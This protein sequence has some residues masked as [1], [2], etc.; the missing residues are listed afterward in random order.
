M[1]LLYGTYNPAKL[2]L[3]RR[4]LSSLPGLTLVGLQ[5]LE[6][7][8]SDAEETGDTPLENAR[9]KALAYQRHSG[10]ITLAA[11]SALY[12]NGLPEKEQ[13]AVHARRRN[14]KRMNDSEMIDF[15]ASMAKEF[16]G[17]LTAQYRNALCI[18][19]PDGRIAECFDDSIFSESF[20]IADTPHATRVE[21]FPLDSLSV[22]IDSGAY[23]M[24]MAQA[25]ADNDLAQG[26]GYRSFIITALG[27]D[28]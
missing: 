8:P 1:N 24:D 26:N 18:A 27:L 7:P 14:G 11:D 16:G 15:Y 19:F 6:N 12:I 20:Y 22:D 23:F 13:P 5:E 17:K 25:R 3:M 28:E 10:M 9:I 21:G 4:W 2:D